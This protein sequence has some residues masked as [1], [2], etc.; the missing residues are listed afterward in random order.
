MEMIDVQVVFE[1]EVYNYQGMYEEKVGL[2]I[3]N[4]VQWYGQIAH[5]GGL[6]QADI[7]GYQKLK[8]ELRKIERKCNENK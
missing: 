1:R 8:E 2:R 4:R 5:V 6:S 3:G 7:D